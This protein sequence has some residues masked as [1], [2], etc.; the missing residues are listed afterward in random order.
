MLPNDTLSRLLMLHP[1]KTALDTRCCFQAPWQRDYPAEPSPV[2]PYHLIVEGEAFISLEGQDPIALQAGDMLVLPHGHAH[3]LYTQS[4]SPSDEPFTDIL[5]GQFHFDTSGSQSLLASLPNLMLVRTVG[6]QE[7]ASL[8]SLI[9]LL[10]D[11]TNDARP[12]AGAVVQHLA[13]ALILL[14]LRAWLAQTNNVRGVFA[15]LADRKLN[16]ALHVMMEEPGQHWTLDR[17]AKTCSMSR[18]TFVR[19]FTHVAGDTPGNLLIHIRMAQAIQWLVNSRRTVGEIGE[20]VGYR[21]EAA[22]NRAF[23]RYATIGPGMY[24]RKYC[25]DPISTTSVPSLSSQEVI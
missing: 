17:L 14:L 10:R 4:H 12:G 6:H 2:A 11:E 24:R 23:K 13:S 18:A 15:L 16:Q 22:F 21:S 9:T 1:V 19:S 25:R 5:C 20:A 3:R 8:K 7:F